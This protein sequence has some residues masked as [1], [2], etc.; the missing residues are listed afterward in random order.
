MVWKNTFES[1]KNRV[2]VDI[3]VFNKIIIF[4]IYFILLQVE[5]FVLLK[6]VIYIF[7]IDVA[8][9]FYQ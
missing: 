1:F 2:V 4:D 3:K 7:I 8:A 6:N 9:F 5:I